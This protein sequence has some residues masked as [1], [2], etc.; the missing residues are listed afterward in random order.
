MKLSQKYPE[1]VEYSGECPVCGSHDIKTED[2]FEAVIDGETVWGY[3]CVC[4]DCKS[5]FYPTDQLDDT[6][7]EE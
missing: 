1:L 6:L 5:E 4:K 7:T 3:K 2:N